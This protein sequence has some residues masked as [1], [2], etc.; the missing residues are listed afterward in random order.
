MG[1]ETLIGRLDG[2]LGELRHELVMGAFLEGAS[3]APPPD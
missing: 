2:T 3:L 1:V